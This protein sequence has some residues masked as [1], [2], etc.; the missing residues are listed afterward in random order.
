MY[1][2]KKAIK[3]KKTGTIYHYAYAVENRWRKKGARQKVKHYLGKV[4]FFSLGVPIDFFVYCGVQEQKKEEWLGL[5]TAKQLIQKLGEWETNQHKTE[6][7]AIDLE[8]GMISKDGKPVSIELPIKVEYK[9]T[10]SPPG[11]RGDSGGS[12]TKKVTLETGLVVDAPLF[13]GEGEVI[14]VSTVTGEY[15]E[16]VN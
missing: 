5:M 1:I 14:R 10:E 13:I 6:G 3:N 2:R 16:R 15:V 7:I 12:V 11:I 8:F 9:V 4:H